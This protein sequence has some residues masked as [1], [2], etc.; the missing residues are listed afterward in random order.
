MWPLQNREAAEIPLT[1]VYVQTHMDLRCYQTVHIPLKELSLHLIILISTH[2]GNKHSFLIFFFP[3]FKKTL[4]YCPLVSEHHNTDAKNIRS[5]YLE[6]WQRLILNSNNGT[7]RF[8]AQHWNLFLHKRKITHTKAN[9]FL[10][11]MWKWALLTLKSTQKVRQK[12]LSKIKLLYLVFPFK[13]RG[14]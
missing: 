3:H 14:V 6:L 1:A 7:L 10:R 2:V 8:K 5:L 4:W 12:R 11:S 13:G 9:F